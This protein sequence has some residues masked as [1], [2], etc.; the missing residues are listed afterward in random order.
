ML[1]FQDDKLKCSYTPLLTEF[2]KSS[3]S[4]NLNYSSSLKN[5]EQ[6]QNCNSFLSINNSNLNN[7]NIN[8]QNYTNE[9]NK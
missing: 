1:N 3:I 6:E 4:N 9:E 7:E 8:K 5:T 2:N